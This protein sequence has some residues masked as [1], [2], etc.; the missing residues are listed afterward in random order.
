M[1][2]KDRVMW[3]NETVVLVTSLKKRLLGNQK[4]AR[5][6]RITVDN[7]V[8][9]FIK[10][11]FRFRSADYFSKENPVVVQAT[12]H[13]EIQPDEMAAV[14]TL[15]RDAVIERTAF[16]ADEVESILHEALVLR[17]DYLIKPIDTIRKVLFAEEEKLDIGEI[18]SRIGSF[19][20]LLPYADRFIEMCR[21]ESR[22]TVEREAY[23]RLITDVLHGMLGSDP[24]GIVLQDF[25]VLTDFLSETKG[26]E[27]TRIEIDVIH[28]FL[29]D[30]NLQTFRKALEVEKNLGSID[31][32]AVDLEMTLKRY[33][34]LKEE[35]A[36][37]ESFKE[38]STE[39]AVVAEPKQEPEPTDS[40][41][42]QKEPVAEKGNGWDLEEVLVDETFVQPVA[43]SEAEKTEPPLEMEEASKTEDETIDDE[44][45]EDVPESKAEGL[46]IRKPEVKPE[47]TIKEETEPAEASKPSDFEETK[48][49]DRPEKE[50]E[51]ETHKIDKDKEKPEGPEGKDEQKTSLKAVK[52]KGKEEGEEKASKKEIR[53]AK[54]QE[55][56]AAEGSE[57]AEAKEEGLLLEGME[58][59]KPTV[60][61]REL[62]DAKTEK[63]F[64]K[65]LF[66][67]ERLD[68]QEL[69]NK[70]D[71]AESWRVA[72]ILI[73]NELFKRDADPFSRE[74]IKLV[75]L[76]YSRY[77]PDE[78]VGGLQ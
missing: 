6:E 60:S 19:R 18:E 68:Y 30:R 21:K 50:E 11:L 59:K 23:D 28:T 24:V 5:L 57:S 48:K 16:S 44:V 77:Y 65:K 63:V 73:D 38:R 47:S 51:F 54:K 13:F 29:A 62:V 10:D 55:P 27:V 35:F 12:P 17:L 71:E 56:E 37:S 78:G 36:N 1:Y 61:F 70:L 2:K 33:L 58:E 34:Q 43:E 42:N 32:N 26:E 41:V 4:T 67:G 66:G 52:E 45:K 74:A 40:E 72:K 49:E 69:V 22:D 46:E 25:S 53:K 15:A 39:D 8:P 9:T 20:K 3:E 64:I 14:Q 7:G 76:V 75:D 31:F